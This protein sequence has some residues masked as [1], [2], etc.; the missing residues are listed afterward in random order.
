MSQ[1]SFES[2]ILLIAK[3]RKRIRDHQNGIVPLLGYDPETALN[4]VA[5]EQKNYNRGLPL[6]GEYFYEHD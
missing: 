3:D 5:I 4:E 2:I 6:L 1:F